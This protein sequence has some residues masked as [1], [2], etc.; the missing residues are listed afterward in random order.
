MKQQQQQQQQLRPDTTID[1][2]RLLDEG[3]AA[4]DG[5]N[6]PILNWCLSWSSI[7]QKA[8]WASES[9]GGGIGSLVAKRGDAPNTQAFRFR[10]FKCVF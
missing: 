2:C 1:Y 9:V 4:A 10:L 5:E 3:R 7:V 6:E 8:N